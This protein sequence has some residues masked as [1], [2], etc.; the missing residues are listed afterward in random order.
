MPDFK[1]TPSQ[2]EAI[3]A[4]G[5]AVLVSA[6]AGSGKTKVLTERLMKYILE[7]GTDIDR[8][9]IITFTKA[10]ASELRSR[11]KTELSR[12]AACAPEGNAGA[13]F[14]ARLR[15]QQALCDKA[16]IGTI[17][18]FCAS[19]L[20][21]NGYELDLP[22]GFTILSDERALAIR[23]KTLEKLL[24]ESYRKMKSLPG[25]EALVNSAGVGRDDTKLAEL[26]LQLYDKMQCHERPEL[27]AERCVASLKGEVG[28]V[29]ET[30]WGKAVLSSVSTAAHYWAAEFDAMMAA[31]RDD[32]RLRDAY[33]D[34]LS[35][36]ADCL[37]EFAR[38][39][40]LGWDAARNAPEILFPKLKG[41]SKDYWPEL[42]EKI[43]KRRD[44]CKDAVKN[45]RKFF[46][47]DS[48]M[49]EEEMRR[50]APAMEALLNLTIAFKNRF[51]TEKRRLS[52]VDYSDLEHLAAQLL[53]GEDGEPTALAQSIA[54]RYTE[55]MVDEYQDVSKVQDTI[56]RA[57]SRNGKNLFF[58]G[59]VKQAIYRFR[60]ADPQIF[61]DKY[62]KYAIH[63]TESPGMPSKILLR[64]NFR[65]GREIIN[66][67]NAVFSCCMSSTLGDVDYDEHAALIFGAADRQKAVPLPE[68]DLF[69]LPDEDDSAG[70]DR[71]AF[72]AACV[73]REI[74][75]LR[76]TGTVTDGDG[77]RPIRYGDIAILLRSANTVGKVYSR[78]LAA[79]GIPSVMEQ[80]GGLFSAREAAFLMDMLRVMDNPGRDVALI[81]ALAS[82]FLNYSADELAA[83]RSSSAAGSFYD[84]FQQYAKE[85]PKAEQFLQ[86]LKAFREAAPELNAERI[87]RM[88]IMET[89]LLPVCNAMPDGKVR[90]ANL[91]R[92]IRI[93]QRFEKEGTYGLHRFVLYLEKL[94]KKNTEQPAA[95][96]A[97]SAVQI[98]TIHKSKGLEFPIVF[99]C[100]TARKFNLSDS[101]ANVLVHPELGLGPKLVDLEEHTSK[102]TFARKAIDMRMKQETLSEEMRL[103]YV[104]LTRAKE[105]LF[106]TAAIKDP[107]SFIAKQSLHLPFSGNK[108]EPEALAS[109]QRPVEW[110]TVAA[111]ADQGEHL[112]LRTLYAEN[113]EPAERAEPVASAIG[114]QALLEKLKANLGFVYPHAEASLLPSKITATELKHALAQEEE[115]AEA[116]KLLPVSKKKRSFRL[117]DFYRKD[118][119]ATGT[120]R[121][122]ATHLALQYM[123]LSKAAT[124]DG[125]SGEIRRLRDEQFLSQRQAEAVNVGA[126]VE[127]FNSGLGQRMRRADRIWR[128]FRFSLLCDA[129]ELLQ[130]GSGE[131]ILLQGVVDCCME[132]DGELVIIDYKTDNVH[133]EEQIAQRS[134]LYESQIKA[135]ALAL[136]RIFSKPVRESVLYFLS[137]GRTVTIKS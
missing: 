95:A 8:F 88:L 7:E 23:E 84:A 28:D 81:G 124:A 134:S 79:R 62:R 76:A 129:G 128:E 10:S 53:V 74:E 22:S 49:L 41:V 109:A 123:D 93:A 111:L 29:G 63:G 114:N 97:D 35:Q 126:I 1:P 120:E 75:K 77:C 66:A 85:H 59:D 135:Y 136:S 99:L 118:T 56:F 106:I 127:L 31:I 44:K 24:D 14:K 17:H 43:K 51:S 12:A 50:T 4:R 65:S 21:E 103:M 71:H 125:V 122:I 72:E 45:L 37:R 32:T 30:V 86:Q 112:I 39:T 92:M 96:P 73:A 13:E 98:L 27:W 137:C 6:G 101:R 9:V 36:T 131:E 2:K 113:A 60:L 34:S 26:I 121:G 18:A 55:I 100:D 5:G 94:E 64:E 15:R 38:S 61:N 90:V 20:R 105:R 33:M 117:P 47:A 80:G 3:E 52:G 107:E 115:D 69:S 70:N 87:V 78:E 132:E 67:V 68:L 40:E 104:A 83:I 130:R 89:E 102:P 91:S 119:P 82:P 42:T 116:A 25:F 54:S 46:Y 110:F 108:P 11:I 133:T 57:V 58:V 19:L 16:Q 48:A